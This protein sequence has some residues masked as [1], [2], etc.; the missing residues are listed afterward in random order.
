VAQRLRV[1][2][3]GPARPSASARGECGSAAHDS[4]RPTLPAPLRDWRWTALR[5]ELRQDGSLGRRRGGPAGA[6]SDTPTG[7]SRGRSPNCRHDSRGGWSH[8]PRTTPRRYQQR[9][10]VGTALTWI[11]QR[12]PQP[13]GTEGRLHSCRRCRFPTC[14]PT[15]IPGP[16]VPARPPPIHRPLAAGHQPS[17]KTIPLPTTRRRPL[18]GS[19]R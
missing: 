4:P 5:A 1:C 19:A 3:L 17:G 7:N 15:G 13:T 8:H 6:R 16:L 2:T 9:P 11:A 12:C 18:A 14:R 10:P